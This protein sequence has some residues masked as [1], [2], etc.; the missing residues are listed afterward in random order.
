MNRP[1]ALP[2]VFFLAGLYSSAW[3]YSLGSWQSL[4]IFAL[5]VLLSLILSKYRLFLTSICFFSCGWVL[6]NFLA[7]LSN[8]DPLS[9]LVI[10]TDCETI[11]MRGRIRET[12]VLLPDENFLQFVLDVEEVNDENGWQPLKGKALV[13]WYDTPFPLFIGEDVVVHGAPTT[14]LSYA[15]PGSDGFARKCR[16]E[17]I[18]TLIR[19]YGN[20]SV[21]VNQCQTIRSLWHYVSRFRQAQATLLSRAIPSE[22]LPFVTAVWLGHRQGLDRQELDSYIFSGTAHILAVSGIHVGIVFMSASFLVNLFVR[23]ERLASTLTLSVILVFCL[24]AGARPS[25]LRATC[26]VFFYVLADFFDRERDTISALAASAIVLPTFS[27][28]VILDPGFQLSFLSV[29]SILAFHQRF[30]TYLQERSRFPKLLAEPVATTLSAQVL[31]LPLSVRIFNVLPVIA[32]VSNL[33]VVPLL[34]VVLWLCMVTAVTSW[35]CLPVSRIFGHAILPVFWLIKYVVGLSSHNPVSHVFVSTPTVLA[36]FFFWLTIGMCLWMKSSYLRWAVVTLCALLCAVFW[37]P[38]AI[39]EV[40]FLDVGHGDSVFVRWR[41]GKTM[42]VDGGVQSSYEDLG[43]LVLSPFLWKK[44][45]TRLDYLLCTHPDRDHLGGLFK[46]LDRFEIGQILMGQRHV[47]HPLE[48]AFLEE[49]RRRNLPV[50]FLS[51][52][53]VIDAGEG[54]IEILHPGKD[55]RF[56]ETNEASVVSRIS[57]ENIHILLTGDIGKDVAELVA[58][59]SCRAEVMKVPHHGSKGSFSKKLVDAVK[60]YLAVVSCRSSDARQPGVKLWEDEFISRGA[61]F[62]KTAQSGAV[63]LN[64][65]PGKGIEVISHLHGKITSIQ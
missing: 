46:I 8:G 52:G 60:P 10:T 65:R 23:R 13:R 48:N 35:I 5:S 3:G 7:P 55:A 38:Q 6:W 47:K 36:V 33:V 12:D 53:D 14:K 2:A 44:G 4:G 31:T 18:F 51:Q 62:L 49:C 29:A 39:P 58:S 61:V 25:V 43:A 34:G 11:K 54:K 16:S 21:S 24:L 50:R 20:E 17:N 30:S 22:A 26:M 15:N 32:P 28:A 57:W 1:L 56:D 59:E 42:L 45:I 27:P 63:I 40:T 41:D 9:Q 19:C 37:K 64:N